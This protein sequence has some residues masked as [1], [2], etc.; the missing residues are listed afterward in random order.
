MNLVK[1]LEEL[2]AQGVELWIEGDACGGYRQRL[3]YRAPKDN[4][5]T[6]WLATIKE[7]KQEILQLL[8]RSPQN[9]PI[10]PL[11]E[12]QKSLWFLYQLAPDSAAYN[13]AFTFR[14]RSYIDVFAWRQALQTLINRHPMLR[15]NF[16]QQ[17]GEP[18]QQ[19]HRYQEVR[20][21]QIDATT[22]NL[23][24]LHTKVVKTHQYPFD[25]AKGSVLEAYLFTCSEQD[26]VFLLKIHH[27][28]CDGW[29]LWMLLE[30]LRVVYAAIKS[31]VEAKLASLNFSYQ[32]FVSSQSQMLTSTR[33]ESLWDYWQQK[34]AGELPVLNLPTDRPRPPVQ[35]YN[36]ASHFF[37]LSKELSLQ[38]RKLAQAEN[39]TPFMLLL[40]AYQ[41]LLHRYTGQDDILIGSPAAGRN[42]LEFAEIVGYFVNIVI[43]R[44][45][46]SPNSTFKDFLAQVRQT[47]LG[48]I[49]HEDY[50]FPLL[51]ERLQPQRD[52]SRPPLFQAGF[53]LQKPQ[54]SSGIQELFTFNETPTQLNWG[55]LLL[56][57][58][59]IGQQE[60]KF[61]LLLE[62]VE[63]KESFVGVLNYNT[64][65]FDETTITQLAGHFQTLIAGIVNNTN[66][67]ISQLPLLTAPEKHQLLV[68]WN[69]TQQQND[70]LNLCI[71]E[72][73]E[74]QVKETPDA[75]A[76]VFQNQ[77]LT[78]HELN[79]RANQL[80]HY[81]KSLGVGAEVLVGICVERSLEMLIGMLGV[82]K[83]GGAYVPLD[84]AYPVE[85]LA[86]M[87]EDAK[88]SVLLTQEKLLEKLPN[89]QAQVVCLDKD[90]QHINQH[91]QKD[92]HSEVMT[93]NLAY[94]IYTS[95]TTGKPKGVLVTHLGLCNLA[96]AQIQAFG[97]KAD[98]HI[99]QFASFSFDAS[100]SEI[101]MA[102][103]AGARLYITPQD[104]L[105]PGP[106]F[107]Q[108]L[109]NYGITHITLPPSVLAAL[110]I[111]PLPCLETIIVAG[112]AC[113]PHL[114]ANWT[115]GRRF[116]NAYGPT[117][118]SVCTTIAEC[119]N[120]D[121]QLSIGRAIANTQVFILDQNFQP[122]PVGV[123]GEVYI[124]GIGLARGYLNRPELTTEKFI[125]NPFSLQEQQRL[126]KT[127]DLARYLPDGNIEF[128]G[129]LDNQVKIRGFRIELSEIEAKLSENPAVS[130]AVVIARE[131]Q[132][133]NQQIVAYVVPNQEYLRSITIEKN[134]PQNLVQ[135]LKS[136]L[137]EFL[138][139]YMIP[140]T[141]MLLESLPLSPNGKVK[142]RALPTPQ[143]SSLQT[144]AA[145]EL[146]QTET[147]AILATIWRELLQIEKI[148]IHDSFFDLGGH[149]LLIA[150]VN[151]KIQEI[152]GQEIPPIEIF[153]YPTIHSFAKYL[154]QN[155][156]KQSSATQSQERADLR[157]IRTA[158]IQQQRQLRQ[159]TR[160]K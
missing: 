70:S 26:H 3:R 75:V 112:E 2:S 149:S 21:E 142:K 83:A 9:S 57:P 117:E 20:F 23:D 132:L 118:A 64:D 139:E 19:V 13:V 69:N 81:L 99:L 86:W 124:G 148:G 51:V 12:G 43:L 144:L 137:R 159:K 49:S 85:R 96:Q 29:S 11:S 66:Q 92:L 48:A 38:L 68:E 90:W 76:V 35:T 153:K 60:G 30:E 18:V 131:V 17:D 101:F 126:Y 27:I 138:P 72:L 31:G 59:P 32:D 129:R 119:T 53:A 36:G 44:S 102:L 121:K 16:R 135:N 40:A 143:I 28:V 145:N 54:Q 10:Y 106:G 41:V 79:C 140:N 1:F 34:L 134:Q 78:Y 141:V 42:R 46:I 115:S 155:T 45:Q 61:D 93:T 37:K 74:K 113:P 80:A 125:S 154:T 146:P 52:P 7:H 110:P 97:V 128:L 127:G 73:F 104:S 157:S 87:L 98:S 4:F 151:V 8:L 116:F 22:W 105:L 47:V 122:V 108:L 100:V 156:N 15:V 24:E 88:V 150:K 67:S 95:G 160:S 77:Q 109:R 123:P 39:V 33:S 82:L 107:I 63:Q 136:Y 6:T 25:L 58:F 84:P 147:E 89:H 94:V 62:F 111:E 5:D 55:D 120:S 152:F 14:I 114:L 71:H 91:N 50:P 158:A 133:G 103:G 65:L 130:E 56:E